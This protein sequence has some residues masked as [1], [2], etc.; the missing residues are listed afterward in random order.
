MRYN[1]ENI[2]KHIEVF[3]RLLLEMRSAN[4][5]PDEDD[6][7]ATMLRSLPSSYDMLVQAVRMSMVKVT[8]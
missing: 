8:Y 2:T 7:C 5:E 6:I 3:E 1:S 4:C